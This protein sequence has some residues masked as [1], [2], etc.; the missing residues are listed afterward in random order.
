M[1]LNVGCGDKK[2]HGYINVD[3]RPDLDPDVVCDVSEIHTKFSDVELIY[4][5]HVLEHF[6][7]KPSAFYKTTWKQV[8][9][10]WTAA[11]KPGGILRISVPDMQAV[12]DYYKDAGDISKLYSLIWGGQKYDY[13]FHFHGWTFESLKSDLEAAGYEDVRLYN[14][15]KTDHYFIDDYSQ[16]YLPH[17][18]KQNGK[19]MS[20]NVEATKRNRKN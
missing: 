14:W 5:C 19:L 11:L 7:L 1:K 18:D 20:L 17:M 10:S 3:I 16:A 13:D 8:L 6:P 15:R 4:A 9:D 12:F 2:I